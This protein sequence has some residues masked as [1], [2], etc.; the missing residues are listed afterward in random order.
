MKSFIFSSFC[1][2]PAIQEVLYGLEMLLCPSDGGESSV[3]F[4][5]DM[6]MLEG[7]ILSSR[8]DAPLQES[9]DP[10]DLPP[11]DT[12]PGVVVLGGGLRLGL[13]LYSN[14]PVDRPEISLVNEFTSIIVLS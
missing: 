13:F 3:S 8:R 6:K 12:W 4:D 11:M 10:V 7:W 9:L 2:R 5:A 14:M 1:P